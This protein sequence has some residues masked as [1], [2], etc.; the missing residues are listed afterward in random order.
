MASSARPI[1][2]GFK[3]IICTDITWLRPGLG[4]RIDRNSLAQRVFAEF[5]VSKGECGYG[6]EHG[7]AT[8][9]ELGTI[10]TR[11]AVADVGHHDDC[12]DDPLG[13][14]NDSH[15]YQHPVAQST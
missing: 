15:V 12:Y 7:H 13:I 4:Q 14:A 3:L 1:L 10:R 9:A 8:D 2:H 6:N 11:V 5:V